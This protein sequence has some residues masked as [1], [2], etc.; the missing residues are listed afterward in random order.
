MQLILLVVTEPKHVAAYLEL[1]I[2]M[3][4]VVFELL[5][6]L[7]ILKKKRKC[8]GE[9][10]NLSTELG[11]QKAM[12]A[13]LRTESTR[14]STRD[15]KKNPNRRNSHNNSVSLNRIPQQTKTLSK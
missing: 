2:V 3:V 4:F 8:R 5:F 12:L 1:Y 11:M 10:I 6:S 7:V 14:D 9:M 15:A 13:M